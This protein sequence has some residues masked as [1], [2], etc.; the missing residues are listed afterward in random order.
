VIGFPLMVFGVGLGLGELFALY[1]WFNVAM[2]WV[3]AAYFLYLAWRLLGLRISGPGQ[4]SSRPLTFLEGAAFQ[5]VNP[6]AWTMATG[7]VA[8]LV[9]GGE[10]RVASIVWL[11]L[12]CLAMAP[13]STVL[14]MVFGR[15]LKVLLGRAG[16]ERALGMVLAAMMVVA[17]VLFVF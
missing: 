17:I 16:M 3:A 1:P 10:G 15:Q 6:K 4:A 11:T 7:F 13:F 9:V 5:W 12:G 2:R 8:A 14:W